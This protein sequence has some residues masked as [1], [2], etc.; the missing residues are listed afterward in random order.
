MDFQ[1][2]RSMSFRQALTTLVSVL[3]GSIL[4]TPAAVW[5][6]TRLDQKA[7]RDPPSLLYLPVVL[8]KLKLPSGQMVSIP[9]GNFQMGCDNGN[10]DGLPCVDNEL[11]LHTVQLD[12]YL[13]DKYE[14]TNAQYAQCVAAGSCV[15]P[16]DNSSYSRTSYY[17]NPA[18]ADYPVIYISWYNARDYCSW[19][20]KRLPSEAE[21]EKAAR[22]SNGATLFPWGDQ[23]ATCALA[24]YD[25]C[26]GDT[27]AVG[28]YLSGASPYGVLD[29]AGNIWEWVNDWYQEDYYSSL[30]DPSYNP[31]GTPNGNYKTLRGGVMDNPWYFLRVAYRCGGY[32]ENTNGDVGFRC[33]ASP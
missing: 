18:F 17:D 10:N 8:N 29:M 20:G 28:S 6:A 24:N 33:A 31:P 32:P 19:S 22:G 9:A 12:A 30:P 13:I 15:A 26:V 2:S 5:T 11:P 23:A 4:I 25:N 1:I 3:L 7:A 27:S 16:T 14:V 21:W